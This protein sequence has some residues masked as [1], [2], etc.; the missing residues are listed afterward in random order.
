[1]GLWHSPI[2]FQLFFLQV[3]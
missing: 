1:L 3:L 2:L